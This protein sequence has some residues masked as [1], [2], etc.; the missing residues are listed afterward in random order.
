M[1][2]RTETA[3]VVLV[4]LAA[5]L[6]L[7]AP[8]VGRAGLPGAADVVMVA[9][10]SCGVLAFGVAAWNTLRSARSGEEGKPR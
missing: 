5:A 10:A 6:V 4:L 7:A 2:D 9:A 1:A 8:V 3:I